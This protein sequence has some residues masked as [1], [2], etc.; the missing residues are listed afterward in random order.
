MRVFLYPES[1]VKKGVVEESFQEEFDELK[2]HNLNVHIFNTLNIDE[3]DFSYCKNKEVIYR[4]WC[5]K[6][7]EYEALENK[8]REAGGRMISTKD[9]YFMGRYMSQWVPLIE[10]LTPK[11]HFFKNNSAAL[12]FISHHNEH[13]YF[14]KDQVKSLKDVASKNIMNH[15][16][17]LEEWVQ[18]VEYFNG[19]I[20][21]GICLREV[22]EFQLDTEI[23]F[24]VLD[25]KIYS[26][27]NKTIV[28]EIVSEVAERI[29]LPFFSVDIILNEK[30][31][32]RVVEITD[33]QV[34]QSITWD[35]N[36][37]AKIFI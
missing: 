10:E 22:E 32:W 17:E 27:D 34:S 24:F 23:R 36:S 15:R 13:P 18:E 30:E 11:T 12:E 29:N 25:G 8:I 2:S 28:P 3:E 16:E 20:E 21:G 1:Y 7:E 4:G 14:V 6:I 26:K 5:L 33:G 9:Q 37:F 31:E 35:L 19:E